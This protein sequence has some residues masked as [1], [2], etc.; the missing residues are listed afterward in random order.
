MGGPELCKIIC[1][2]DEL[3]G[4]TPVVLGLTADTS[5]HVRIQCHA[6]G[7]KDVIHKPITLEEMRIYFE[8]V[9]ARLVC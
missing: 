5:E 2:G 9:V 6:S 7:M 4:A 8:N 1:S 3:L